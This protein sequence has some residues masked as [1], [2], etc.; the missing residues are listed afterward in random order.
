LKLSRKY[1]G[2]KFL[3][4]VVH[5]GAL[6]VVTKITLN[7][8]PTYQVRQVLYENLPMSALKD[9]FEQ[10]MGA[11]YSVSLFTD[12][13]DKKFT[14][15]W[16]KSRVTEKEKFT[17]DP[18]FFGATLAKKNM[19]PIAA[20]SAE[21]CTE[22]MGVPGPWYDRLPHF[23]MGFTPSAGKELQSEY[24]IP[25]HNAVDAIMAVEKLHAQITPHLLITE[26]RSISGDDLW[27]SPCRHQ[28]CVTIHF[29]WKPEW[30][31]VR[32]LLP[33]I[34]KEII[35][36][37]ARPHWGKL[38]TMTPQQLRKSYGKLDEFIDLAKSV[39]PNGKFR[40]EFLDTNIFA[41]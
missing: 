19:H 41:S 25:R 29:T 27:M 10:I 28:D 39:D 6:G 33:Q 12:W 11:A 14:E 38:F 23:K 4:A 8:Q 35:P 7:I 34:E 18:Q 24:F 40:N 13:Q 5:L 37:R 32:A 20:L 3:G 30:P 15:V 17:A 36:F 31:E 21:N 2:E 9:H 22:Q 1:D 16:L 26:I